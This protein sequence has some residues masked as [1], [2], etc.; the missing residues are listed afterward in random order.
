MWFNRITGK[1]YIGSTIDG[2]KRFRGYFQ[3]ALLKV[4]SQIYASISKYGH[5]AFSLAILEVC[6]PTGSVSKEDY[7][8]SPQRGDASRALRARTLESCFI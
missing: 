6:G 1:V 4:R 5:Q 3:T 8:A 2:G 7:L